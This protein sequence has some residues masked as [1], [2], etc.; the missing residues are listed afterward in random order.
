MLLWVWFRI[1]FQPLEFFLHSLSVGQS[2]SL[3][4]GLV[5]EGRRIIQSHI[6]H[7]GLTGSHLGDGLLPSITMPLTSDLN[8]FLNTNLR[9]P[10]MPAAVNAELSGPPMMDL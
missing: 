8:A 9:T 5:G 1:L 7:E 3:F 10:V 2:P 4:D 6:A